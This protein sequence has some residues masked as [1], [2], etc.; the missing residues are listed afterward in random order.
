MIKRTS[1]FEVEGQFFTTV[2]AAQKAGITLLFEKAAENSAAPW[3]VQ[4][5]AHEIVTQKARIMDILTF[6]ETSR[7]GARKINGATKTRKQI[8]KE[9]VTQFNA[10]AAKAADEMR[11]RIAS[12]KGVQ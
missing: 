5:I 3:D 7:P 11:E 12:G 8:R 4:E 2:E 10:E 9:V 6:T 1:G